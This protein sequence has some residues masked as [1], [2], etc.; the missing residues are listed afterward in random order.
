ME[1]TISLVAR[2]AEDGSQVKL[3]IE[4]R[5]VSSLDKLEIVERICKG[6]ETSLEELMVI[7]NLV[8]VCGIES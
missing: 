1:G 5:D 4:L 8:E 7:R 2:K 6:L 3:S